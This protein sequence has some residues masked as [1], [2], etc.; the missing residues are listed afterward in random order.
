VYLNPSYLSRFYKLSTG[1][2]LSHYIDSVRIEKAKQLLKSE[3]LKIYK[4]AKAVGYETPASFTRFFK[5]IV[6]ISPQEYL[7]SA[8]AANKEIA[9]TI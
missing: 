7:D 3:N 9:Q 1:I 4:V 6:G 2:N 5:K 8:K